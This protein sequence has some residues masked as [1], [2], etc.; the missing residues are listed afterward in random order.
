MS[1]FSISGLDEFER[2]ILK[3][4]MQ[5]MPQEIERKLQ[6]LAWTLYAKV[7]PKTP[8]GDTGRLRGGWTVT[9][10]QK[11]DDE[12]FIVVGNNVDY[13]AHREFGHRSK[14]GKNFIQG[15]HMLEISMKQ[16]QEELPD[17]LKQWLRSYIQ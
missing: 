6:E 10:V 13:A 1:G 2:M 9:D 3:K 15:S 4:L 8:V 7:V 11:R 16:L 5:E 17:N 14:D 12:Y